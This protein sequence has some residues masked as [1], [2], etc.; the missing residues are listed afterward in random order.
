MRK[1][2]QVISKLNRNELEQI[3]AVE[4]EHIQTHI[5]IDRQMANET[6]FQFGWIFFLCSRN[7]GLNFQ[8][9][10]D[11]NIVWQYNTYREQI[12]HQASTNHSIYLT[13]IYTEYVRNTINK[14]VLPFLHTSF[15]IMHSQSKS[16][17]NE[18]LIRTDY[19]ACGFPKSTILM[20]IWLCI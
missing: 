20:S 5:E 7:W 11:A 2:F 4:L 8:N 15:V 17:H 18:P 19:I 13:T 6:K 16:S 14:Q 1:I 3:Y 10:L 12:E 9:I